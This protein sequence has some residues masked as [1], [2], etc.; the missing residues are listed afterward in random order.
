MKELKIEKKTN[1]DVTLLAERDAVKLKIMELN[2]M[3]L[4]LPKVPVSVIQTINNLEEKQQNIEEEIR[5]Q[6]S[7][8]IS[9]KSFDIRLLQDIKDPQELNMML[10]R[11]IDRITVY[12]IDKIWRIKVTYKNS[13][14]QSF[15]WD[16]KN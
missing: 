6:N 12:N 14:I 13:H 2:D 9:E 7:M 1:F 8:I 16:G 11:V 4:E 10:K 3:L 15:I 5:K